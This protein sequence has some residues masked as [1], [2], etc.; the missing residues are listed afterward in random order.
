[1]EFERAVSYIYVYGWLI[2]IWTV[3]LNWG[4]TACRVWVGRALQDWCAAHMHQILGMG[5]N[6]WIIDNTL[7][8]T[9]YW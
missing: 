7:S 3:W 6:M 9:F 8:K 1:M 4:F 2:K 5:Y